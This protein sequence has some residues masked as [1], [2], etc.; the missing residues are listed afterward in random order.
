MA[1]RRAEL[2]EAASRGAPALEVDDSGK[3]SLIRS[4]IAL[5]RNGVASV[6][7]IGQ[8]GR[9]RSGRDEFQATVRTTQHDVAALHEALLRAGRPADKAAC[10]F[11]GL[12]RDLACGGPYGNVGFRMLH[13]VCIALEST[14]CSLRIVQVSHSTTVRLR[15]TGNRVL[16]PV[17]VESSCQACP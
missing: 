16:A 4:G 15:R 14:N 2:Q 5:E 1:V 3:V 10:R 9:T 8:L 17:S 12:R 11:A 7:V 6:V 13:A